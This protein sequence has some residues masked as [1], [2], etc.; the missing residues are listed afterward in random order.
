MEEYNTISDVFYKVVQQIM[1]KLNDESEELYNKCLN[2]NKREIIKDMKDEYDELIKFYNNTLRKMP[3]CLENKKISL[4]SKEI[5]IR[6]RKN[7]KLI[8]KLEKELIDFIT[9]EL[10]FT[11]TNTRYSD[12]LDKINFEIKLPDKFSEEFKSLLQVQ[13]DIT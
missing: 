11:I 4:Y 6:I 1:D 10:G 5:D 3:E 12:I 13:L 7:D 2:E 8:M 9:N